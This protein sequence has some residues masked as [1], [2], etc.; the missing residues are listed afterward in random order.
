M[1]AVLKPGHDLISDP[2]TGGSRGHGLWNPIV[3]GLDLLVPRASTPDWVHR[4]DALGLG[5]PSTVKP[6]EATQYLSVLLIGQK[7]AEAS[8]G[9]T[10]GTHRPA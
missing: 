6:Q 3:L 5:R 7:L 2:P 4:P 8:G 9:H 1:S 10:E